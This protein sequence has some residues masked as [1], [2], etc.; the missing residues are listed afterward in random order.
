MMLKN[1]RLF[2]EIHSGMSFLQQEIDRSRLRHSFLV[3]KSEVFLILT[4]GYIVLC[5]NVITK[6][7]THYCKLEFEVKF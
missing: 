5:E 3:N 6:I 4:D 2:E 1:F 7:P